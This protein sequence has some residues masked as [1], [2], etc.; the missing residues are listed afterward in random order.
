LRR[1]GSELKWK[2]IYL[3]VAVDQTILD[4]KRVVGRRMHDNLSAATPRSLVCNRRNA[5]VH[6]LYIGFIPYDCQRWR[7]TSVSTSFRSIFV[8]ASYTQYDYM[9]PKKKRERF[10]RMISEGTRHFASRREIAR[11]ACMDSVPVS[12]IAISGARNVLG[13]NLDFPEWGAQG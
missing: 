2:V 11:V 9:I 1:Q 3:D 7:R 10:R 8:R 5:F 4:R 12:S 13:E 6:I